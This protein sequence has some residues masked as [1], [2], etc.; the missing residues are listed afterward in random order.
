MSH[1]AVASHESNEE[2]VRLYSEFINR[3]L[4]FTE[5]RKMNMLAGV[6]QLDGKHSILEEC[7]DQIQL[8]KEK[9]ERVAT[10]LENEEEVLG[11]DRDVGLRP[12]KL[13]D[14]RK[15]GNTQSSDDM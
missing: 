9:E 6:H 11:K 2:K 10:R 5:G 3:I 13:S 8:E 15:Y 12:E 7:L 1:G 14:V 4:E